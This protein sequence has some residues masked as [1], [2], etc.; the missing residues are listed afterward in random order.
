MELTEEGASDPLFGQLPR[1]F[2]AQMGHFDRAIELPSGVPNL[3]TSVASKA[4]AQA[5]FLS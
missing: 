4:P 2:I 1:R 5:S 3:A